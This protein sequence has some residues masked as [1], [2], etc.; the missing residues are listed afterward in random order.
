MLI[1][2]VMACPVFAGKLKAVDKQPALA[3]KGVRAVVPL[4]DA[5]IVAADGYWP[6]KQA[7]EALQPV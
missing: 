6:A 5:V 2:T 7:I 3:V 4:E 1:A